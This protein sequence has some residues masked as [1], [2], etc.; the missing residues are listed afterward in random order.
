VISTDLT[1][2]LAAIAPLGLT[3]GTNLFANDMPPD[4]DD[5]TV[6]Y[7][8]LDGRQALTLGQVD[9]AWEEPRFQVVRRSKDPAAARAG[10]EAVQ[11]ELQKITGQVVGLAYYIEVRALN[12]VA[13]IKP[14]D[15]NGRHFYGSNF[16]ARKARG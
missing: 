9:V 2:Y 7:E 11:V 4:P 10:A 14:E 8:Y 15:S 1:G 16:E 5:V 3:A 13:R 12:P 6:L